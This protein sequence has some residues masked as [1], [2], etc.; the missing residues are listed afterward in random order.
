VE[1]GTEKEKSQ[2]TTN[3]QSKTN[4]QTNEKAP[5]MKFHRQIRE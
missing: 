5:L 2:S 3:T 4:T 1:E